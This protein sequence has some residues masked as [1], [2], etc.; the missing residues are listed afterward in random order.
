MQQKIKLAVLVWL[1][2]INLVAFLSMGSDKKAAQQGR[3]R[4][5]EKTLF[6]QAILGGSLGAMAGMKFFHHKTKHRSFTV[7]MPFILALQLAFL[8]WFLIR[9]IRA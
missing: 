1:A 2:L 9:F 8:T 7:G 6:L 3:R 4:T 5:P